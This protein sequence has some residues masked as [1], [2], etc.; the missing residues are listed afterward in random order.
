M[1]CFIYGW[2]GLASAALEGVRTSYAPSADLE[3]NFLNMVICVTLIHVLTRTNNIVS[4]G[5]LLK[6]SF[7]PKN[8]CSVISLLPTPLKEF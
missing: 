4:P 7:W 6:M 2:Q 8:R 5:L 3:N 1:A